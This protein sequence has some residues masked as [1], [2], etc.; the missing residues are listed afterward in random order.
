MKIID[1]HSHCVSGSR[2]AA[3]V[4]GDLLRLAD[5]GLERLMVIMAPAFGRSQEEIAALFPEVARDVAA[6][7]DDFELS[8]GLKLLDALGPR[9]DLVAPYLAFHTYF[10]EVARGGGIGPVRAVLDELDGVVAGLKL[11]YFALGPDDPMVRH[12]GVTD[13]DQA[14]FDAFTAALLA[15]AREREIPAVVHVDLRDA[16][17][18]FVDLVRPYSDVALCLCHFGYSRRLC[19]EVLEE[20]PWLVTD[21]SGIELHQSMYERLPAYHEF[22]TRFAGR[23][24]YGSDQYVCDTAALQGAWGLLDA[25][26]LGVEVDEQVRYANAERFLRRESR[27]SGVSFR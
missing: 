5:H 24:L 19:A 27:R 1:I 22:V 13:W 15:E 23:V 18:A 12:F 16:G 8:F 14:R 4:A 26:E 10:P 20:L 7:S 2:P 9:R 6:R 3:D 21:M 11:H 17:P 25:L